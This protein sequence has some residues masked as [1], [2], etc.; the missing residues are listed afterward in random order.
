MSSNSDLG[1]GTEPEQETTHHVHHPD[2]GQKVVLVSNEGMSFGVD[3]R[4]LYR[5]STMFADMF[6]LSYTKSEDTSSAINSNPFDTSKSIDID[7]SS[8]VLEHFID[9]IIVSKPHLPPSNFEDTAA[10]LNL[11]YQF[12]VRIEVIAPIKQQ[13]QELGRSQP[14]NLLQWASQNN[15]REVGQVAL[16]NMSWSTFL[17]GDELSAENFWTRIQSL[18]SRWGM[19]ILSTALSGPRAGT[20]EYAVMREFTSKKGRPY[21]KYVM[22]AQAEAMFPLVQGDFGKLWN[23]FDKDDW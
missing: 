11:C 8:A 21:T 9:A 12:D 10:L 14:W 1:W 16:K 15:N 17:S 4:C 3:I 2:I 22:E 6:N 23:G 18:E 5:A 20:M 7:A 13:L 19:R